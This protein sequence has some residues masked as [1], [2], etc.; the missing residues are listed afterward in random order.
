MII[1]IYCLKSVSRTT[2]PLKESGKKFFHV[3][4]AS[5]IRGFVDTSLQSSCSPCVSSHHLPSECDCVQISPFYK[6]TI[7]IGFSTHSNDLILAWLNA[8][9][10]NLIPN[11]FKFGGTVELHS[12]HTLIKYCSKFFKPGFTNT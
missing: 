1:K 4:V 3:L 12:S 8:Q 6:Y 2:L 7:H 5:V 9:T 11:K 10:N